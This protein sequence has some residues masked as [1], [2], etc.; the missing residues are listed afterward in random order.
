M[1][2]KIN[3]YKQSGQNG[4]YAILAY[5]IMRFAKHALIPKN[6][7]ARTFGFDKFSATAETGNIRSRTDI[8]RKDINRRASNA[9]RI[10]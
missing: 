4:L 1:C 8:I 6:M 3:I 7:T 5:Q 9:A 2:Y 10:Q